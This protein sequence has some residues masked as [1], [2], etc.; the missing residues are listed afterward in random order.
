MTLGCV[1]EDGL[2]EIDIKLNVGPAGVKKINIVDVL[3]P[4]DK[5]SDEVEESES[6]SEDEEE[7]VAD[8]DAEAENLLSDGEDSDSEEELIMMNEGIDGNKDD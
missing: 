2:V 8:D 1:Q 7:D 5:S 6:D 4:T 3:K